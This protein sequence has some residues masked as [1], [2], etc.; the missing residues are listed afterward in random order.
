LEP[1]EGEQTSEEQIKPEKPE[2]DDNKAKEE[3]LPLGLTPDSPEYQKRL[4]K[5]EK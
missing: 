2:G 1:L 5:D 4:K 3:D